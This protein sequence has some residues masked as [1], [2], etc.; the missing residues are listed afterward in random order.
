MRQMGIH[1]DERRNKMRGFERIISADDSDV[2]ILVIPTDEEYM[3][4]R[5]T[6]QVVREARVEAAEAQAAREQ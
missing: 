6:Y 5:D 4:A 1:L 2:Q 3:I